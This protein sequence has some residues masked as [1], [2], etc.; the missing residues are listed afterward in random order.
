MRTMKILFVVL[1]TLVSGVLFAADHTYV[2]STGIY[3]PTY[4]SRANTFDLDQTF[5]GDLI[6]DG[7][8]IGVTGD[9]DLIQIAADSLTFNGVSTWDAASTLATG[10]EAAPD[11]DAGGICLD[12]NALDANIMTFKS[13][14]VAHGCT[15]AAETDT[16]AVFRKQAA[17]TGGLHLTGVTEGSEAVYIRG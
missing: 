6:V 2:D 8:E 16:Y 7:G 14:D 9:L 4:A 3:T 17:A 1:L 10:G 13:S 5:T 15:D 12:Q 11:V